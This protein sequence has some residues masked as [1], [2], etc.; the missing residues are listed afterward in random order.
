MLVSRRLSLVFLAALL[1]GCAGSR[2]SE[3]Y[4]RYQLA[5]SLEQGPK[6]PQAGADASLVLG[7]FALK[8]VVD[9]DTLWV[10]G[11]DKSLRLLAID[12]EETFKKET[13]RR[14]FEEGWETYLAK[15]QIKRRGKPVKIP[16]PL[17]EDAKDY[18]KEFFDGVR[19][20]RLERDHPK[21][22]R[23]RFDRHL[24]YVFAQKDGQWLNYNVECVRAGMSPY[25][26]K[27][28]YSRRFHEQFVEAQNEAKA[29]GRGIWDPNKQHYH[30]Y[31]TRIAWWNRR[32]DYI[33]AF[34]K[35]AAEDD[36]MIVLTH[37]DALDRLGGR[38]QREVTLLA[39]VGEIKFGNGR[40]PTRAL[41]SRRMFQDFPLIFFDR[42]VLEASNIQDSRGDFIRVRGVVTTYHNKRTDEDV[43][44]IVLQKPGQILR[45]PNQGPP[46]ILPGHPDWPF[47]IPEGYE[48]DAPE[49]ELEPAP[50]AEQPATEATPA[51]PPQ[52]AAL[53]EPGSPAIPEPSPPAVEPAT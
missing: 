15:S 52:P 35:E 3:R 28:S 43:L 30:D 33:A 13:E 31:D 24:V 41:L 14:A 42:D 8:K 21:E 34:E 10:D 37:W 39:T 6:A 25:F 32:A 23:G 4:D 5:K 1:T 49:P 9:G 7:E 29:A 16:T 2:P 20:V 12:T 36:S 47:A 38:L 51:E 46:R 44:Q 50:E 45:D 22:I 48:P 17:G 27:Y 19:T 53:P 40:A 11:L 26:T 18:A